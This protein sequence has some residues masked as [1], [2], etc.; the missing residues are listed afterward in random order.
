M[1]TLQLYLLASTLLISGC[2]SVVLHP[3]SGT[4]IIAVKKGES[5]IA[6]KDGFFLSNLYMEQVVKA[7][8]R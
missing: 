5:V 4:D 8:V 2:A 3:I 7:K 6:P 1:A